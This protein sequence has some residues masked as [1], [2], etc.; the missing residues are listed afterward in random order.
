[1]RT[2]F[3]V[4]TAIVSLPVAPRLNIGAWFTTSVKVCVVFVVPLLAVM[5]IG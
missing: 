5:V 3:G 4:S 2:M 1:M